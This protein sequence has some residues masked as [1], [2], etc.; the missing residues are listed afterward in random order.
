MTSRTSIRPLGCLGIFGTALLVTSYASAG[1]S[2]AA[3]LHTAPAS[4][5]LNL[6]NPN[7]AA[8]AKGEALNVQGKFSDSLALVNGILK[9]SPDEFQASY[10]KGKTLYLSA[11]A[12][13][14]NHWNPPLPLS[15]SMA[16]GF[17]LLTTTAERLDKIPQT[18]IATSNPYSI[19]NTI[20]AFY[21][22]R[23]YF[24]QAQ[25]YLLQAYAAMD[26]VPNDTKMK[27][28]NNL[29]LVYLVQFQPDPSI[30]YYTEAL[31]YGSK[32]A[33]RQLEKARALKGKSGIAA[34]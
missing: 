16:Q 34:E 29:G 5:S 15:A 31:K 12:S 25:T 28:C 26:K 9:T 27:I 22:D 3:P 14:P 17:A 23:G 7:R 2:P 18:C 11:A 21:L 32:V 1:P 30:K 13:E 4:V 33:A 8:L 24:P 20:G 19:M 10:F 6:C